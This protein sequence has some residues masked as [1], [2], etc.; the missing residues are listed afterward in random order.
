MLVALLV[1]NI[2][3][4]QVS[5]HLHT[6]VTVIS[7]LNTVLIITSAISILQFIRHKDHNRT[8]F[9]LFNL[10]FIVLFYS[11]SIPFL[12]HHKDFFIGFE[13]LSDTECLKKYFLANE[14]ES[15]IRKIVVV[16]F[17]LNIIYIARF[18]KTYY[19]E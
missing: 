15:W 3:L 1:P 10:I 9:Q 18:A 8:P 13:Q 16:A 17:V 12:L 5:G 14:P 6:V 7:V 2:L 11:F 19:L 4:A